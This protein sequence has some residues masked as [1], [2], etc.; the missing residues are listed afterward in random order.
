MAAHVKY[1]VLV[2]PPSYLVCRNLMPRRSS[3][4]K[5]Y[6]TSPSRPHHPSSAIYQLRH[7]RSFAFCA[8]S[9][10]SLVSKLSDPSST[11]STDLDA[12]FRGSSACL[13]WK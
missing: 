9:C 7:I 2:P 10:V 3:S 12:D 6:R 11:N 1:L 8:N 5:L 4:S 13:V